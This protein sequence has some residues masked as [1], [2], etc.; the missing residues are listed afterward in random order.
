MAKQTLK[1]FDELFARVERDPRYWAEQLKLEL[2]YELEQLMKRREL[3]KKAFAEKIGSSPSYV[4]K[5]LRGNVNCTLENIAK[6]AGALDGRVQLRVTP[7]DEL[8]S[9]VGQ[10]VRTATKPRGA[11]NMAV[12]QTGAAPEHFDCH[13]SSAND[14][15]PIAA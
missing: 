12:L 13:W 1:G 15:Q 5:L 2:A 4:T 11:G 7:R 9:W 14:R 6:L 8:A 10:R 3:G